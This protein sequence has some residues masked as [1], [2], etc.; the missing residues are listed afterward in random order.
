MRKIFAVTLFAGALGG[1]P[2]ARAQVKCTTCT[3]P[4]VSAPVPTRPAAV[5]RVRPGD[6]AAELKVLDSELDQAMLRGDRSAV[7]AILDEGM[8]DVPGYDVVTPR[9]K[10]LARIQPRNGPSKNSISASDV[11]V[12]V[13]GSAAVVTSKKVSSFELNG[14]VESRNYRETNTYARRNGRWRLLSSLTSDEDPPY[15]ARDLS[16]DLD[17]DADAALGSATAALVLY[18]FSDYECPFC[19]QFAAQTLARVEKDYVAS[20]RVAM[21]FRDYPLDMHPRAAAAAAAGSCAES[22]GKRWAMSDRLLQDP[23]ALSDDD[24]RRYAREIGLD[25]ARF[26]RCISDPATAEKIR[27]GMEEAHGFGVKGT[28]IF[29]IGVRAPDGKKV[30]A[31]RMI[32][33]AYPYEVFQATL[34]GM[35][36]AR[37]L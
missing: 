35:L 12:K 30:H 14:H 9:E 26:D 34:D 3:V 15:S 31:V 11:V 19:R 33:G 2:L 29:V 18:E 17:F 32:E 28:P 23:V 21:V 24:F 27:R 1:I 36:R 5:S 10:V 13:S 6:P 37:G 22:L 25:S 16:I 7:E 4:S 8:I 20:G